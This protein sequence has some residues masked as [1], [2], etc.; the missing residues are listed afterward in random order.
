MKFIIPSEKPTADDTRLMEKQVVAAAL[1]F[2]GSAPAK[3]VQREFTCEPATHSFFSFTQ[4]NLSV[5]KFG[6]E[7]CNFRILRL[8]MIRVFWKCILVFI[9]YTHGIFA[10]FGWE[11]SILL[12]E[13]VCMCTWKCVFHRLDFFSTFAET[14]SVAFRYE[15]NA[16]PLL[17]YGRIPPEMGT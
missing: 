14:F 8:F 2:I 3:L 9:S 10:F 16:V 15:Y 11:V 13:N 4:M 5:V 6:S 12:N 17:S 1:R 7:Q